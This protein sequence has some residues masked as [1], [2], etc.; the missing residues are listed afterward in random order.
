MIKNDFTIILIVVF[1][2]DVIFIAE[3]IG[4]DVFL[5]IDSAES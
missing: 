4:N 3:G 5:E 2:D 1:A